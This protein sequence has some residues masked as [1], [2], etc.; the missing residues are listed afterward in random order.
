MYEMREQ[1]LAMFDNITDC[2]QTQNGSRDDKIEVEI[3]KGF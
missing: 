1:V 3:L 2:I